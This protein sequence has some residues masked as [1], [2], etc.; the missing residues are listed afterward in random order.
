MV[1]GIMEKIR[2]IGELRPNEKATEE[3]LA[4]IR[5][6]LLAAGL[7]VEVKNRELI[8]KVKDSA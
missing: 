1:Q 6:L 8:I 2:V 3:E 5:Y 7:L 4:K